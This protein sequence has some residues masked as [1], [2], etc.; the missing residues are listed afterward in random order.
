MGT[1]SK[2]AER[3]ERCRMHL[4]DCL[5]ALLPNLE[6]T[7]RVVVVMHHR[8]W[9]RPTSTARLFALTSPRCEIRLRGRRDEPFESTGIVTPDRRAVLLHP[10]EGAELL[11]EAF[12]ARDPRPIT[13]VVPDGSWRQADKIAAREP[14][15]RSLP[16]VVLPNLGPSRYRL[17]NEP[18]PGGLATFEAISRALGI[19]EGPTI[20]SSLD[21]LFMTMVERTLATRNPGVPSG[22]PSGEESP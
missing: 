8:E 15:L 19:L 22:Q 13:L 12:L 21:S 4:G 6:I 10:G 16:K 18:R 11:D 7:T 3:C 9:H 20:Q 5:C 1:R 17:R 2:R 14:V